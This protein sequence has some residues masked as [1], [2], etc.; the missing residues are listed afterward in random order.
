MAFPA[1]ISM[2]EVFSRYFVIVSKYVINTQ[3]NHYQHRL[4]I[5]FEIQS[6]IVRLFIACENSTQHQIMIAFL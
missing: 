3:V 1:D 5:Q 4:Q 6:N 2:N